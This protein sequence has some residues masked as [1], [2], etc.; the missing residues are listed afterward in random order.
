[1]W[2]KEEI[3]KFHDT[4]E[5][6]GLWID[7][8][9]P[10][11]FV[12]GDSEKGGCANNTYNMPPYQTHLFGHN[13][14]EGT[15]CADAKQYGGLHYDLHNMYGWS[16]TLPTLEGVRSSTGSRGLVLSR[17][18]FLG[19][20]RWTAHW[21][22][23]NWSLWSNLHYSI[24]GILQFNQFGIPFVGADICGFSLLANPETIIMSIILIKTQ[25]CLEKKL[26]QPSEMF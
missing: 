9:E 19:S 16:Q 22:G 12:N 8:N 4:I 6:D 17:S 25:E 23:D 24:I 14:W 7:M 11:N 3:E 1:M 2:W 10:A 5:W 18:T 21:L 26:S 13:W 20:G 15:V